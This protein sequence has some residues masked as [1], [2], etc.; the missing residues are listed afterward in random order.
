MSVLPGWSPFSRVQ[1]RFLSQYE[2]SIPALLE[3]FSISGR[4]QEK[5]SLETHGKSSVA[6]NCFSKC[7]LS[8]FF[9]FLNVLLTNLTAEILYYSDYVYLLFA[10]KRTLKITPD[11][12]TS[13]AYN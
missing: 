13:L 10:S 5:L 11:V 8:S 6:R 12:Y 1:C 4:E 2:P 9:I 7:T 3:A